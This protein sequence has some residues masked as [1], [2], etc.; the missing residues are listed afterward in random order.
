M[1]E[2][3]IISEDVRTI[4]ATLSDGRILV[5]PTELPAGIGWEL[6]PEGLCRD[7]V[8]VPVRDAQTLFV[9]D[10]LDVARVA[11]A[12]GRPIVVDADARLASI[13]LPAEERRRALDSLVAPSFE[14]AD[15]EGRSHRLEEW[16][17]RKRLLV[18]FASW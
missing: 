8:C 16:H 7:D 17:G 9:S 18:A 3:T 4:E 10:R 14:L 11:D 2:V 13:A 5:D 1:P 12:L 6:K 15:L